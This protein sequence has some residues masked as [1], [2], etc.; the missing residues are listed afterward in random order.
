MLIEAIALTAVIVLGALLI[1]ALRE[2]WTM[3]DGHDD[4]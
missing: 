2:L 1:S 3:Y 4:E